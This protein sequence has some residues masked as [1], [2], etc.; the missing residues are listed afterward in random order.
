MNTIHLEAELRD[1]FSSHSANRLKDFGDSPIYLSPLLKAASARDPL[2]LKYK[3]PEVIGPHHLAPEEWLP[4]ARTV[5][6]YFLPFSPRIVESNSGDG[7]P[8][9]EWVYGRI[10][11]ELMNDETRRFIEAYLKKAG[12]KALVPPFDPRYRV[13]ERRSTWSERHAAYAAGLGTFGL[14]RGL[15][16]ES[17]C[18]GRYGSVLTDLE[19]EPSPRPYATPDEY[20]THCGECIPRCPSGAITAAGKDVARCAAYI[21]NVVKPRFAPRYGCGKCQT[22]VVCS[23]KRP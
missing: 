9:V 6:S 1:F 4:G 12:G 13:V 17:G 15:I 22:R 16:T 5:L 23:R 3:D 10:E 8:S 18:A 19:F 20:C 7:L 2:F 21:D 11:G 14:S